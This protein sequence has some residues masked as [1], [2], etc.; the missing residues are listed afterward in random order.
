MS[1][2]AQKNVEKNPSEFEK[3]VARAEALSRA[4]R[5]AAEIS[6]RTALEA[7]IRA[8]QISKEAKEAAET[9]VK[10]A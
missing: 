3:A 1:L 5:Q 8:E 6:T 9:A 7:T 4:A 10:A 2:D